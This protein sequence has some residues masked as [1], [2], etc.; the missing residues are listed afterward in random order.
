MKTDGAGNLLLFP[1]SNADC[2]RRR[3]KAAA[4]IS[5]PPFSSLCSFVLC[6]FRRHNRCR[7]CNNDQRHRSAFPSSSSLSLFPANRFFLTFPGLLYPLRVLNL[8]FL[9]PFFVFS[10]NLM[11]PAWSFCCRFGIRV[12]RHREYGTWSF[13]FLNSLLSCISMALSSEVVV[14]YF[15]MSFFS[16]TNTRDTGTIVG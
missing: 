6:A 2:G 1:P 9:Q 7:Y 13:F 3:Y 15:F 8:S 16:G 5:Q 14:P 10:F 12:N 11:S 4:P